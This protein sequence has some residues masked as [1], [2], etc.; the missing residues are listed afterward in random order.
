MY[1]KDQK[2]PTGRE[3]LEIFHIFEQKYG[4]LLSRLIVKKEA[5]S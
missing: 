5:N 1:D 3:P 2:D 4:D